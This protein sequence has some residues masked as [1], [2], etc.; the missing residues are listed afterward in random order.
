[1][2]IK[3][4]AV[5][6]ALTAALPTAAATYLPVGPQTNVALSTVTNG[7]WTQCYSSTYN[8]FVG[9]TAATALASCGTGNIMLAA[10]AVGSSTLLLLAQAPLADVTFDTGAANNGTTHIANGTEWYY[11]PN[12]SWGFAAIGDTVSKNQCDTASGGVNNGADRLCWH[13][14]NNAGG[15]RIGTIKSL[16]NST[17]YERLIFSDSAGAVP[18]PESWALLVAGFALTGAALRRRSRLAT[19]IG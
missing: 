4:L 8:T 1:M 19:S 10:R 2:I 3:L 13:T 9:S 15:Y 6:S 7:G 18:E 5:A 16:N 12:W 14:I 17:D 11:A